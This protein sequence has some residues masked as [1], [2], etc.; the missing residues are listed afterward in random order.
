MDGAARYWSKRRVGISPIP[1]DGSRCSPENDAQAA[2]A[3]RF[4]AEFF[5]APF[6][7]CITARGDGGADFKLKLKLPSGRTATCTCDAVWL[8][9]DK[10]TGQP[11]ADGNL[12][13]N[14]DEP[15]R[16][17][18][19]YISVRGT[20]EAGFEV[21]GWTTHGLLAQQ[22]PADFGYGPKLAMRTEKL[23]PADVLKGLLV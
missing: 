19:I 12:I 22:P 4:A 8:G 17:A 18:N 23:R 2:A 1:K 10:Y 11:R 3:E 9:R 13:V 20:V 16:W 6:N 5:G 14:P 7:A 21:V 15:R